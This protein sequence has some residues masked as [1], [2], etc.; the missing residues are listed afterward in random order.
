MLNSLPVDSETGEFPLVPRSFPIIED[1]KTGERLYAWHGMRLK[2]IESSD[3]NIRNFLKVAGVYELRAMYNLMC[4]VDGSYHNIVWSRATFPSYPINLTVSSFRVLKLSLQQCICRRE[5]EGE[6][7][8]VS[9][10]RSSNVTSVTEKDDVVDYPHNIFGIIYF[11][12]AKRSFH[13]VSTRF[14]PRLPDITKS[15]YPKKG[16]LNVFVDDPERAYEAVMAGFKVFHIGCDYI[17]KC[18]RFALGCYCLS[19]FR[20]NI[21]SGKFPVTVSSRPY[22]YAD[23]VKDGSYTVGDVKSAEVMTRHFYQGRDVKV[24][25]FNGAVD[26]TSRLDYEM[27]VD[28][29]PQQTCVFDTVAIEAPLMVSVNVG[30]A[31]HW[32]TSVFS[33]DTMSVLVGTFIRLPKGVEC[34]T[35]YV[36]TERYYYAAKTSTLV[37]K[38]VRLKRGRKFSGEVRVLV[39]DL[40]ILKLDNWRSMKRSKLKRYL[41]H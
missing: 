34:T 25:T 8:I 36:G 1:D 19:W 23:W 12:Y 39:Y 17:P 21:D 7:D 30:K 31:Y 18:R 33:A 24:S 4:I 29:N 27:R 37:C 16:E 5:K 20:I 40:S 10:I 9:E 22:V 41:V 15:L 3:S 38:G 11:A 2:I 13:I 28:Y 6:A 35:V 26:V 14:E 32:R